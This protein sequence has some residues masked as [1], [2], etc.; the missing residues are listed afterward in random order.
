MGM[1]IVVEE[2]TLQRCFTQNMVV[3]R[4]ATG[5]I[6]EFHDYNLFVEYRLLRCEKRRSKSI[7]SNIP[8]RES[9]TLVQP[10]EN[11]NGN[12]IQK[13]YRTAPKQCLFFRNSGPPKGIIGCKTFSVGCIGVTKLAHLQVAPAIVIVVKGH[14]LVILVP[15]KA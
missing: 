15:Y 12:L 10:I 13:D 4:V 1:A 3:L 8:P 11:L 2:K 9:P 7:C 6:G 5:R 14:P